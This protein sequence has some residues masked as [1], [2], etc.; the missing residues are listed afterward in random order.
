MTGPTPPGS[1]ATPAP[2]A[3]RHAGAA[4]SRLGSIAGLTRCGRPGQPGRPG[5]RRTVVTR[6]NLLIALVL[7]V[8]T[9]AVTAFISYRPVPPSL[10]TATPPSEVPL[11]AEQLTD[12]RSVELSAQLGEERSLD[13]PATGRLS[14]T[15]CETGAELTSGTTTFE[16]DGTP[17]I[18]LHTDVPLWRPLTYGDEGEDVVALQNELRRLGYQASDS[19]RFDWWT[20]YSW[21]ELVRSLGGTTTTG[22]LDVTTLLWLPDPATRIGTCPLSLGHTAS[23][24]QPLVALPPSLLSA[25]I[26][27]VP[28]DLVPG[29]RSLTVDGVDIAIDEA[30]QVSGDGLAALARTTS[31]AAYSADPEGNSLTGELALASP[32]TVYPLPPAALVTTGQDTGCVVASDGTVLPVR[33]V[34]SRL[35]RSYVTFTAGQADDA[36]TDSDP[37]DDAAAEGGTGG[38]PP[39]GVRTVKAQPDKGTTCT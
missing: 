15:T 36:Q 38:D 34:A 1:A 23:S 35:G 33:I 7:V 39:S 30:G 18:N 12:T 27:D 5:P 25:S 8:I 13:S 24:G 37:S 11:T 10:T 28:T 32:L 16:V 20:W 29:T 17:I 31:F 19:G 21:D 26:T 4:R 9:A 14:G 22:Q 3:A 6:A 2:E